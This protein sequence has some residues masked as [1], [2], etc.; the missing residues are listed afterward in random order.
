M[1][2]IGLDLSLTSTGVAV[3]CDGQPIHNVAITTDVKEG[4]HI[5]RCLIIMRAINSI[6]K[7]CH[8]LPKVFNEDFAF[9]V[10]SRS[11]QLATLGELNGIIKAM[12]FSRIKEHSIPVPIGTWKAFLKAGNL[13]KDAFKLVVFQKFGIECVTNDEAAAIGVA[14][15]G[16]AVATGKSFSGAPLT[17]REQEV[18]KRFQKKNNK[19]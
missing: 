2:A 5:D 18:L 10:S 15:F 14:D 6:I 11:S 9:G 4:N 19:T 17:K 16:Y 13:K 8:E 1:I 3:F 7:D 12:V